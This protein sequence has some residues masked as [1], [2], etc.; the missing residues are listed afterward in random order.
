MKIRFRKN[1]IRYRLDQTD[2]QNLNE[3]G[4]CEEKTDVPPEGILFSLNISA[5]GTGRVL[6]DF[7]RLKAYI[8]GSLTAPVITGTETGFECTVPGTDG[9]VVKLIVERDFKCLVPRGEED[10]N[11]FDN[12]RQGKAA[13]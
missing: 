9:T 5:D 10:V 12:P 7:P 2:V 8:P 4:C 3:R 6:F 11:S 13:C 1:T